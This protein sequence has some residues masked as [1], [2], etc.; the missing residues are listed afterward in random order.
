MDASEFSWL[1]SLGIVVIPAAISALVAVFNREARTPRPVRIIGQLVESSTKIDMSSSPKAA[2]ALD[3]L[4]SSYIRSVEADL[5]SPRKLN[6]M[7]VGLA[8]FVILVTFGAMYLLA[9]WITV[10]TGTVWQVVA[11]VVTI[12]A[13]LFFF[14][15]NIAAVTTFYSAPK[16]A[17]E[18]AA[19]REAKRSARANQRGSRRQR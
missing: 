8:V 14:L 6:K 1:V 16:S 7:N 18:R 2:E 13:G 10:A 3:Q 11:W 12:A 4:T 19:E 9:S 15:L 5:V 17:E